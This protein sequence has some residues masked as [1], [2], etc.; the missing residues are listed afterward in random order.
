MRLEADASAEKFTNKPKQRNL[1]V[2]ASHSENN[3]LI[4]KWPAKGSRNQGSD[5]SD[6]LHN[7]PRQAPNL[8]DIALRLSRDSYPPPG[9]QL[10]PADQS[11]APLQTYCLAADNL[12]S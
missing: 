10:T 5:K 12:L 9:A 11:I 2:R 6:A 4:N 3:R 7:L 8:Q 1:I